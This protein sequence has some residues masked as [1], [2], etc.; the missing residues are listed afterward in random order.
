MP[1]FPVPDPGA[2]VKINIAGLAVCCF[3]KKY[4]DPKYPA[5]KGRWEVAIPRGIEDH[6]LT[7]DIG[8]PGVL[9]VSSG[10]KTIE[11]K[12]RNS[13]EVENPK[14]AQKPFDRL[15]RDK[16]DPIDYRW[17]LDFNEA[18]GT[19]P[20]ETPLVKTERL[21][22]LYIY[23]A[24]FYSELSNQSGPIVMATHLDTGH[25]LK[26]AVSPHPDY[27][28]GP[29][30]DK[31]KRIG[32]AATKAVADVHSPGKDK[33][34]VGLFIDGDLV[35]TCNQ[36]STPEEMT[37]SNM[38]LWQP[39]DQRAHPPGSRVT[40][41]RYHY[42]RGDFFRYYELFTVPKAKRYHA[43]E[44][45]GRVAGEEEEGPIASATG[46][47]NPVGLNAFPNLSG[48]VK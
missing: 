7:I 38:E 5:R 18:T 25:V 6:V 16:N 46:D 36:G 26:G 22:M 13:V 34:Q 19:T 29:V 1:K 9:H 41:A 28:V 43:W 23:D 37:I 21:T 10:V 31:A 17:L 42:G 12:D 47:C 8:R 30:L 27:H 14:H 44:C 24:T 20:K 11:I 40:T 33:G 35:K 4:R 3:N 45:W 32:C 48:L 39:D 2:T 15:R